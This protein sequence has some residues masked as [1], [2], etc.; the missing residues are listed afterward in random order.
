MKKSVLVNIGVGCV[1]GIVM[2]LL[3]I[4]MMD[5]S[6]YKV[7]SV[8][9]CIACVVMMALPH[10]FFAIK[11]V[12]LLF[13]PLVMIIVSCVITVLYGGFVSSGTIVQG[14][15]SSLYLMTFALH[16]IAFISWGIGFLIQRNK[17]VKV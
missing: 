14:S 7:F 16:V 17:K 9:F 13:A 2:A 15:I 4:Y 12:R 10:C 11:N 8:S 6:L 3:V 5:V 1:T